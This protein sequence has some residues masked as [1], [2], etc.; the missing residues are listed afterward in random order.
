ML[1]SSFHYLLWFF[2]FFPFPN[3]A[4]QVGPSEVQT[5]L[6]QIN[7]EI[8]LLRQHF[9][10][11]EN[12]QIHEIKK[13]EFPSRYSWQKTYEILFKIN[14]LREKLGLP[15]L[16]VPSQ[17]PSVEVTSLHIYEQTR[18]ILIELE[19]LKFHLNIEEK[20][21]PI[22]PLSGKTTTDNFNLLNQ[23]SYQLDSISQVALTPSMVFSQVMRI[24]EDIN[25]LLETLEITDHTIPP[26]KKF[27]ATPKD[28]FEIGLALLKEIKRLHHLAGIEGVDLYALKLPDHQ[29]ITPTEVFGLTGIILAELE[30]LK[31]YLGLKHI[32]T[33]L[34]N[35]YYDRISGDVQQ[36]LGWSLRKIQLIQSFD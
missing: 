2:M 11:Q 31:G 33:P 29:V 14:I 26:P 3:W 4:I 6:T 17:Q 19:L 32:F 16:A 13:V 18:R 10:S 15:I 1:K 36:I 34:A 28:N 22:P 24:Y 5:Q 12:I 23:I 35:F 9:H 7:Q 20:I 30:A 21:M 8:N 25:A 27:D